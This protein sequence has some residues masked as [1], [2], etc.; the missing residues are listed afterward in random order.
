MRK[1]AVIGVGL[2]RYGKWDNIT[3][4]SLAKE[5]IDGALKTSNLEWNQIQSAWC[6]HINQGITAGA[7]IFLR[8]GKTGLSITNCENASASGSYAF[9][10]AYLEV[11][12]GEFDI[13]LALG[14][15]KRHKSLFKKR[16]SRNS[17]NAKIPSPI[18]QKFANDA[19]THMKKYGT[20]VDQLANISV[21]NHYNASLNP[22][23]QFQEEITIE[24]VH[25]APMM[26]DPLTILHC[27]STSDGAAACILASEDMVK[28]LGISNPVWVSASV[29]KSEFDPRKDSRNIIAVTAQEAYKKAGIEPSDLGLV[30]LHDAFTIEEISVAEQLG[31]CP[32]GEGGKLLEEGA[33]QINGKI[34]INTSGGLLAMGHPM[35]PTGIGQVAEVYWQM[36][37]EAGKRQIPNP[38]KHALTQM[39]GLGGTCII[40]IFSR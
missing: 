21:K 30:E 9:R 33:T 6:G 10:G 27:T 19:R 2:H 38:P 20:T 18:I 24:D 34:P 40:H 23:A 25:N 29:S 39:V 35:G 31:L 28:K 17:N 5:A 16:K 7:R 14:I 32:I 15:D 26:D 22:Y 12:L 1:V 36:R 4:Y 13:A 37:G 11:A 3:S 8:Y